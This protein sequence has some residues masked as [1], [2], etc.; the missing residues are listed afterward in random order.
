MNSDDCI[1]DISILY[2]EKSFNINSENLITIER[3]KEEVIK[4]FNI[5][6]NDQKNI[7]LI[8]KRGKKNIFISSDNDIINYA[9]DSNIN[10]PKL[11]LNLLIESDKETIKI[12]EEETTS[13]ELTN[14]TKNA[15]KT[16]SDEQI[17]KMKE[18][19]FDKYDE[20]KNII[21]KL[22]KE[23]KE[24][25][26]E[27][28]NKYKKIEEDNLNMKKKIEE[29]KKQIVVIKN[30]K[31]KDKN[32]NQKEKSKVIIKEKYN[33][34]NE[35]NQQSHKNI[36]Q[37][38][39]NQTNEPDEFQMQLKGYI[40]KKI[41]EI[42][43]FYTNEINKEKEALSSLQKKLDEEIKNLEE[44]RIEEI[45]LLKNDI[46]NNLTSHIQNMYNCI[47]TK[48]ERLI[49]EPLHKFFEVINRFDK[50]EKEIDE[51]KNFT[52]LKDFLTKH[53]DLKNKENKNNNNY[54]NNNKD[55]YTKN[56]I[57]QLNQD[58]GVNL[59]NNIIKEDFIQNKYGIENGINKNNSSNNKDIKKDLNENDSTEEDIISFKNRFEE[60]KNIPIEKIKEI[61]EKNDGD[62]SKTLIELTLNTTALGIK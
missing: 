20:L 28:N 17:N 9:D 60:L 54:N 5:K 50:F 4:N 59:D 11:N 55:N 49:Q 1:L 22:S 30:D 10:N 46:E 41:K 62:E 40:K 6:E 32:E 36:D 15:S 43:D 52:E 61:Y 53:N 31:L 8:L 42:I 13:D 7:K 12:N 3:I 19:S 33:K 34:K 39:K 44:K 45:N 35:E 58:N 38:I 18:D 37:K 14:E 25:K 47:D 56:S 26:E 23:I 57:N 48:I 27:Q 24:L 29:C 2:N 16:T 21:Y 51:F